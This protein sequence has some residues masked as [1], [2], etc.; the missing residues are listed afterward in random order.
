MNPQR[1]VRVSDLD[2]PASLIDLDIM[3][4]N[5]GKLSGYSREHGLRV[6]PHTK[7]HKIPALARKQIE[8]GA[9]GLTVAKVGEAE[10]ML[11]A[12]PSDILVAFPTIGAKKLQRLMQVARETAVTMS[13]DSLVVASQLSEAARANQVEI[14]VLAEV[15][16]GLGRVGVAPGPAL[17]ELIQGIARLPNLRFDGIAFYPG[18]VKSLDAEG[19]E[20]LKKIAGLGKY[21]E[22]S[23][24]CGIHAPDRQRRIDTDLVSLPSTGGCE[25]SPSRHLHLQ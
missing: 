5:L 4:R 10:I 22:R 16:V 17:L 8:L 25:R 24:P 12:Q 1:T 7:T 15:D 19:H 21:P 2:T 20:A 6:R 3:D 11:A 14:G 23:R 9:A 13:L 18:Q